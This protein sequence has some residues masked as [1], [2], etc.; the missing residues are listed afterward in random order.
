MKIAVGGD[1]A[2][3]TLRPRI[4][5][6]LQSMGHDVNDVGAFSEESVDYP[7]FAAKVARRLSEG[8]IERGVLICGTG[9][10]MAIAANKFPHVRAAV[11][12]DIFTAEVSRR[13]NNANVLCLGARVLD[14]QA[15][16]AIVR[17]WM[18]CTAEEGRHKRRVGKIK[19]IEAQT[20]YRG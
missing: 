17:R 10:G 20:M 2:S 8:K 11:V 5:E 14:E 16:L 1:H 19:A 18:E 13:H 3:T 6:E 4:V 9:I 15:A 7:D 12:H